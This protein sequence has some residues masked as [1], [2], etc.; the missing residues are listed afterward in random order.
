MQTRNDTFCSCF[1]PSV[2]VMILGDQSLR[3][4][5]RCD[6]YGYLLKTVGDRKDTFGVDAL[7][8]PITGVLSRV[9]MNMLQSELFIRNTVGT[10]LITS[11]SLLSANFQITIS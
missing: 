7:P 4:S 1:T 9:I 2:Q 11:G 3:S 6:R 8:G 5:R 10:K